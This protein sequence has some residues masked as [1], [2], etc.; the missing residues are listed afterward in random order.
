ML[1]VI[2]ALITVFSIVAE[3]SEL[4]KEKTKYFTSGW[5]YVDLCIDAA[6]IA[7][8]PLH[9]LRLRYQWIPMIPGKRGVYNDPL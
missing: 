7:T 3:F 5:N 6:V 8:I 1:Q 2:I 9:I 4:V